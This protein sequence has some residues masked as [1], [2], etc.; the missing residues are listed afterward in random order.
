MKQ[1]LIRYRR[2]EAPPDE[3]HREIS[4]FIA[5]IEADP[6]IRG[7]VDY[8]C[9][10]AR[11]GADY[12]H[13]ATVHDDAGRVALQDRPWFKRYTERTREI[14]GG[15]IEVLPLETIAATAA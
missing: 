8:R 2:T 1:F 12:F 11:D 9:M 14:S 13:I 3:W 10:K 6:A 5:G 15:T 4:A 7:K